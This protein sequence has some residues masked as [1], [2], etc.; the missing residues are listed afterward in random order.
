MDAY[1]APR[2][3]PGGNV[4]TIW[5]A[6]FAKRFHGPP[7]HYERER[8]ATPDGDFIDVDWQQAGAAVDQANTTP[9]LV[10]F[11]GLEGSSAS[12]YS[13]AFA[14]VARTRGWR[15]AVPHFRGA[16]VS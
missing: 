3:L 12:H 4:Q 6:L 7:L 11:H 9:L 8:W 13:Q 10:L 5:P 1:R 2:W 15:F 16:R 14:G